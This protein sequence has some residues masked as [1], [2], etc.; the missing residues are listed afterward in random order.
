[1]NAKAASQRYQRQV[2]ELAKQPGNDFCADCKARNP[3]W[4]SHN[5]GIF[6]C[7]SCAGIHRKMGT[8]VS[9]IKSLTLDE[10]N[11]EQVERMREM[12]NVKS[13]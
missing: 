1:M 2:L 13:N 8:H 12:G 6:V 3:R 7:M 10:W 11:K 9:K 4:A 5:L